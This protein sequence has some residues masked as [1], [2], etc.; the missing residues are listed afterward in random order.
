MTPPLVITLIGAVLGSSVLTA[1]ITIWFT[2]RKIAAETGEIKAKTASEEVDTAS[3]VS[4][5]MQDL[6]NE[7]VDLYKKN[8]EL[9]KINSNQLRTIE[10][11]TARLE[12]RDKQLDRLTSLAKQAPIVETLR[13]QL[14]GLTQIIAKLQDTQT[15][16]TK[17]LIEK[18]KTLQ[19]ALQTNRNLEMKKPG[20]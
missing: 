8:I 6:K 14:D 5:F 15:D 17:M 11:L 13:A 12:Q 19:E 20:Q 7:N 9:E 4:D 2:R 3:K 1:L 18:E 10:T 16:A